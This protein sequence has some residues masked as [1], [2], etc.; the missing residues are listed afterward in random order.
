MN[1]RLSL[2]GGG[3]SLSTIDDH[4]VYDPNTNTLVERFDPPA[5]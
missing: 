3:N 1:L 4:S 5:R 2:V